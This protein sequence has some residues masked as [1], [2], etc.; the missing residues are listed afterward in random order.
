MISP[1]S[2]PRALYH[3]IPQAPGD[4]SDEVT[5]EGDVEQEQA[6]LAALQA[7]PVDPRISW[8]FFLLGCSVLL[9]W[10]GMYFPGF[11]LHYSGFMISSVM[12]TAIPFF[13]SRLA[14]SS[15]KSTFSSYL[16]VSFTV[17]GFVFLAH[18]TAASKRVS[19]SVIKS[20]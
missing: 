7:L 20:I 6:E 13:L 16:S 5:L 15:L 1:T 12:I 10:N 18:A 19:W 9:P 14:N 2:S 4:E 3:A 8:I 11:I 17:T